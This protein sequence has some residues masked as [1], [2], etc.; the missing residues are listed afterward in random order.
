MHKVL[1]DTQNPAIANSGGR[2]AFMDYHDNSEE[3]IEFLR[4]AVL[5]VMIVRSRIE[6]FD[7]AHGR[8]WLTIMA[9]FHVTSFAAKIED[10]ISGKVDAEP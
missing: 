4:A 1:R 9:W 5:L 8:P 6:E 10:L 3:L 7:G 2:V